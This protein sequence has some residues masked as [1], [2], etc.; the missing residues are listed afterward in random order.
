MIIRPLAKTTES[1]SNTRNGRRAITLVESIVAI[2]IV[3]VLAAMLMPAIQSARESARDAQCLNQQR[4]IAAACL[5]HDQAHGHLPTGGWGWGWHGDPDRPFGAK[6]PG[7]WVYAA[8][9]YIEQQ[10][11]REAGRGLTSAEKRVAGK[12]VAETAVPVFNCPTRRRGVPYPFLN[13]HGNDPFYNIDRPVVAGRSDYAANLGDEIVVLFGRGPPTLADGDK[14]APDD[15]SGAIFRRSHVRL[16]MVIDGMSQTYLLGEKALAVRHYRTGA[17]NNDDQTMY[18]GFDRDSNRSCHIA[19]PPVRDTQADTD[20]Q[21]FGSAHAT[22]FNMAMCDGSIKSVSY[23][24][25]PDVHRH[26]GNR[27]DGSA[28]AV[29]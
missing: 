26:A 12:S 14:S 22:H 13:A 20:S 28:S 6:Q 11:L 23:Q 7:G 17:A 29:E 2:G 21:S 10:P 1:H 25:A 15:F 27:R 5:S 8:L 18:A 3:G 4:Q 19:Y 9:P 16:T 24:V